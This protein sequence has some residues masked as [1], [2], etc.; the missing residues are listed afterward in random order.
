MLEYCAVVYAG[1]EI[2][3]VGI[4]AAQFILAVVEPG[5]MRNKDVYVALFMVHSRAF[6][7][8]VV[9]LLALALLW[10]G[11]VDALTD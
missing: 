7:I 9:T 6:W 8:A 1:V 11:V 3:F 5:A 10:V 4:F 2:L